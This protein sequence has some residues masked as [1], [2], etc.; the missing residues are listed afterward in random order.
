MRGSLL[1]I[2]TCS[3]IL[4]SIR[5][6]WATNKWGSNPP[7]I[8]YL[9]SDSNL[10]MIKAFNKTL[11]IPLSLYHFSRKTY[12]MKRQ[13]NLNLKLKACL[14]MLKIRSFWKPMI[15][16]EWPLFKLMLIKLLSSIQ[17]T[18][19]VRNQTLAALHLT[20]TKTKHPLTLINSPVGFHSSQG[21]PLSFLLTIPL[22]FLPQVAS[23]PL[24]FLLGNHFLTFQRP[25]IILTIPLKL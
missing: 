20:W 12:A 14:I 4:L 9:K 24:S 11:W 10:Q 22:R 1:L 3:I 8:K 23:L 13:Q 15:T 7:K 16:V 18:F 6:R 17:R 2:K 5:L 19:S 21:N 25:V